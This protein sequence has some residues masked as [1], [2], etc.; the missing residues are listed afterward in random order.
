MD[1]LAVK[2]ARK[3]QVHCEAGI[4]GRFE[5]G[6]DTLSVVVGQR[7]RVGE[8][9]EMWD[10]VHI[11]CKEQ[12]NGSLAVNVLICNPDWEETKE[13]ATIHSHPR[14]R[15]GRSKLVV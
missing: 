6:T 12:L 10:S 8:Q 14:R 11:V 15:V 3:F 13:V 5:V 2:D 4:A 9:A 7:R 1:V